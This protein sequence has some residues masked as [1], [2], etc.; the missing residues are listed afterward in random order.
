MVATTPFLLKQDNRA[1]GPPRKSLRRH[2]KRKSALD[3]NSPNSRPRR[4]AAWL[5][6]PAERLRLSKRVQVGLCA[7]E[8]V[9]DATGTIAK[10]CSRGVR[11]PLTHYAVGLE[12]FNLGQFAEAVAAFQK[13]AA[14]PKYVAAYYHKARAEI[15]AALQAEA[16]QTLTAGI[17]AAQAA[18]DAKT[19]REMKE[20]LDTIS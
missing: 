15:R 10:A 16:R 17:E 6:Q 19:T 5:D 1:P 14:D 3:A 8:A 9:N 4:K 2:S 18:G 13:A 12:Y 20:L 11:D 7:P